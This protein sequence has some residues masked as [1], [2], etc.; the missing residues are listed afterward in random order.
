MIAEVVAYGRGL[1]LSVHAYYKLHNA[2]HETI[3][4]AIPTPTTLVGCIIIII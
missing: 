2:C 4:Y 1:F 3:V